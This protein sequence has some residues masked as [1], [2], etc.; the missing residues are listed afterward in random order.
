VNDG[1]FTF[2]IEFSCVW[3]GLNKENHAKFIY[4]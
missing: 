2:V 1:M 3:F 4:S